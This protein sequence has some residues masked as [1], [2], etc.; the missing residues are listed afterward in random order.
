VGSHKPKTKT[1]VSAKSEIFFM[2]IVPSL[3]IFS[4]VL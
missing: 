2:L 3:E 1:A 4:A